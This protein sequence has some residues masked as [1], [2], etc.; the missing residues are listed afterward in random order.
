MDTDV[1]ELIE[2]YVAAG[3]DFRDWRPSYS[4]AP[5]DPVAIVRERV[6]QASGEVQRTIDSALWNFHP[7]FIKDSKRP[8]FNARIE[9]VSTNGMWKGAFASSRALVPMRG[10]Y[11]WTGEAGHKQPHFLH[12]ADGGLLTAAGIYTARKVDDEW[13]VSTAIITREARDASGE[14]HDRMPVF[15]ERDVWDEYLQP[16]KLDDA[17]KEDLVQLLTAESEKVAKSITSYKV[18]PKVNNSRTADPQD[19]SLI[20]PLPAD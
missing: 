14:V 17:G 20:E 10:Y 3:G 7:A 9:T 1:N 18:D 8:N 15:L 4:Y 13:Q 6:D 5:T 12:A 16:V 2:E 11:E 19:A